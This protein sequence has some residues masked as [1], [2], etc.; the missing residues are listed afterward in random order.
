MIKITGSHGFI[1][2][3]LVKL[4]SAR[5]V[6][7][8]GRAQ[9]I[10]HRPVD[11]VLTGQALFLR[12]R[13]RED[14]VDMARLWLYYRWGASGPW[15]RK[16]M[17]ADGRGVFVGCVPGSRVAATGL[18]YFL[19]AVDTRGR[20]RAGFGTRRRPVA[21]RTAFSPRSRSM[22]VRPVWPPPPMRKLM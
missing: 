6:P 10:V 17:G 8:D 16:T 9:P 19:E 1:G 4:L 18:Q 20:R 22:Q 21:V 3:K 15:L 13:L 5:P 11:T 12:A 14:F 2:S 7:T